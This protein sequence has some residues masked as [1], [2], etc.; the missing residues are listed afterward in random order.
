M[1]FER[2]RGRARHG[3]RPALE[4]WRRWLLGL[5][6]ALA[7]V[8]L[9]TITGDAGILDASW[10]A[11]TTN[12][13][14]SPLA[15]L[16]SY[17]VYYGS[18]NPPCPGASFVQ[19]ASSTTSPG[20]NQTVT[21]RLTG[22]TTGALY[23][24][25]VTAVDAQ[26]NESACE[27]AA[28]AVAQTSFTVSPTGT[29]SFGSVAVG[30]FVDQTFT[31]QSTRSGTVA[32]TATTAAPFSVVAGSSFNLVGAGAGQ[33]VMVRFTPTMS[34]TVTGNVNFV[35]SGDTQSGIVTGSGTGTR[36]QSTAP[37]SASPASVRAGGTV[38]ATWNGISSPTPLDWIG[39]YAPGSADTAFLAWIYVSCVQTPGA[40]SA[41]GSCSFPVPSG[42]TAGPYELRLFGNNGYTRLA[43]SGRVTV[44]AAPLSASPASVRAGG[45]VTATWN[46]ISSPT[47]LDWIGLYLPGSADTRW[48]AWI[49]VSCVQTPGA[50]SAAGSCSFPVPSG[51]TAGPY[52]L[53]LFANQSYTRLATSNSVSVAP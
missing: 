1:S 17:R 28:S 29:V 44:T 35:A 31:V 41:A 40:A 42:L 49:Y 43:V 27:P 9:V 24:V 48:L 53:R 18:S 7:A 5:A 16:A 52:E 4:V 2:A 46:G 38:T 8:L 26:G 15:D 10:T 22:L 25:S 21:V 33:T 11:P 12:V 19:V 50:A 45:T 3:I 36:P 47:P 34:A 30:T 39:L 51:L 37:L 23:Y 32:G 6:L 13:D 14:G 20:P